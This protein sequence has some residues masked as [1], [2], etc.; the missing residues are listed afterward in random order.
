MFDKPNV[1]IQPT[2]IIIII[3]LINNLFYFSTFL[4]LVCVHFVLDWSR[5]YFSF[6][7]DNFLHCVDLKW[8]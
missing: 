1:T 6:V 2:I 3:I 8:R 7:S 4:G 5:I